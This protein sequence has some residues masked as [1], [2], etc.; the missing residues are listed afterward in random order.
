MLAKCT[1]NSLI[2][3]TVPAKIRSFSSS[4]W[5]NL[6]SF[7][8]SDLYFAP[9]SEIM[10]KAFWS[11]LVYDE[12]INWITT[13]LVLTGKAIFLELNTDDCETS[14]THKEIKKRIG[15]RTLTVDILVLI[16]LYVWNT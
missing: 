7:G 4:L 2:G 6:G 5:E 14:K 9:V 16:S 12:M 15:L 3:K 1:G 10:Q 8:S 13:P 11:W